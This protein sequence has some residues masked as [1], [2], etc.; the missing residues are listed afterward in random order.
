MRFGVAVIIA[1]F[2]LAA[3]AAAAA[4][5]PVG[6][7]CDASDARLRLQRMLTCASLTQDNTTWCGQWWS[8]VSAHEDWPSQSVY[9]QVMQQPPLP[10]TSRDLLQSVLSL[11]ALPD[12]C[13]NTS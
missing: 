5:A 8:N 11:L 9:M 6:I 7:S 1:L 2:S 4:A 12:T 13:L 3:A 10:A